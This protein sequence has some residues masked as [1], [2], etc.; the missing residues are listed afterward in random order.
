MRT[1]SV[2]KIP[3]SETL[4]TVFLSCGVYILIADDL[5]CTHE[6]AFLVFSSAG[7]LRVH[8]QRRQRVRGG[9]GDCVKRGVHARHGRSRD[10]HNYSQLRGGGVIQLGGTA[11]GL[12]RNAFI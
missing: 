3:E 4:E 1:H 7:D 9:R 8:I 6:T 2:P 5:G 12:Y 10:A 11:T